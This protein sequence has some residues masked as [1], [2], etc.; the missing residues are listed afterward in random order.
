MTY[1]SAKLPKLGKNRFWGKSDY[2]YPKN[3][4]FGQKTSERPKCAKKSCLSGSEHF[5]VPCPPPGYHLSFLNLEGIS[6]KPHRGFGI[7]GRNFVF[8]SPSKSPFSTTFTPKRLY[9]AEFALENFAPKIRSLDG[10]S[11]LILRDS[12]SSFD[13]LGG[14]KS[15]KVIKTT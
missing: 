10:V 4:L 6:L 3:P 11:S 7:L 5:L 2:F 15:E 9:L 14:C 12:K 13:I 1:E 8:F